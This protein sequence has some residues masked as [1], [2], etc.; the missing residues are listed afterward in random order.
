MKFYSILF[1]FIAV[2]ITSVGY[3]QVNKFKYTSKSEKAIKAY[4]KAAEYYNARNNKDAIKQLDQAISVDKNFIEAYMLKADIYADMKDY[5]QSVENYKKAIEVDPDFFAG[6]YMNLG[7]IEFKIGKYKDAKSSLES[8]I[9]HKNA[10][11]TNVKRCEYFVKHCDFCI[12]LVND[13]VPFTPSNLGDSVNSEYG[14]YLP[15]ITADEQTLVITRRIPKDEYTLDQ[16]LKEE[17]DFYVSYKINDSVWSKAKDLGPPVNTNGNEGAQCI[18]PDGKTIFFTGCN[19]P[20]GIGSCDLYITEKI[21]N[22]WTI[23]KNMGVIVNSERWDSQPS[24][25]S[26]G[27]TLYFTSAR[28]GG[29]GNMDIWK[30]EKD[31]NGKWSKP[32]NLG[33]TINTDKGEMSPFIHPDNQTLYFASNGHMGLGNYDIFYSRKDSSEYWRKP[34]NIGYP[35]NTYADESYLIVNS[36]GDLAYF[37]SDRKGGKGSLD[38]Y[39]FPLYEKA[40]PKKVTYVK[41]VVYDKETNKKLQAKFELIDLKS[42]EISVESTSDPV[43]GA[44]LVCLPTEKDYA[45]NVSK[46]GYLFF[47][48]NFTLTGIYSNSDPFMKNIPLQPIK[49]G[50][51]VVLKNI[52]FD[53]DKF[54]IKPESKSELDNLI[55]LLQKN[56]NMKIE[57]SGHTDKMGEDMYNQKLSENRAKAVYLYLIQNNIAENRLSYKGYGEL[58]PIDSNDTEEGRANNRRTEFKVIS[59]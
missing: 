25:S 44:F 38:I 19:R 33:D 13:S 50:E 11:I 57:I 36:K 43:T 14:D 28:N 59:K 23:P 2:S 30:T 52:F 12:A 34:L 8:Y 55:N 20:D 5:N 16:S 45:L 1:V 4:E 24:I 3:A 18:S 37:S 32:I 21:G 26:D 31:E 27:K 49:I 56:V 51:T 29:K 48:E 15:S 6:N 46:D 39:S 10:N 53:T 42:G 47:S 22:G 35:I 54:D 9:N 41:G 58:N 7:M 17:E 40:R